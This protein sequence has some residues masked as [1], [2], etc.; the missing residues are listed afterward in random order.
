MNPRT[1]SALAL[2][3]PL[4]A[5]ASTGTPKDSAPS[6]KPAAAQDEGKADTLKKKERELNYARLQLHITELELAA[7]Q[8]S[9]EHALAEAERGVRRAE[10]E[11]HEYRE[12]G[13]PIESAQRTLGL[14]RQKQGMKEAQQEYDELESMYKDEE[15]AKKTKELVLS[16]GKANL[17]MSR[18]GLELAQTQSEHQEKVL[19][20]RKERDL[21]EA[22]DKARQGLEDARGA[23]ERKKLSGE[24]QLLR[25]R[26]GISDL[27]QE[28]EKLRKAG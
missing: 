18:R 26:D 6:A 3:L 14:D 7:D 1:L 9:Q 10:E 27:E 13:R 19:M 22:L 25:A 24:L 21:R 4:C 23:A 20:P 5:C 12:S 17:E 11:L 16:R 15:F 8:R 2:L 28:L